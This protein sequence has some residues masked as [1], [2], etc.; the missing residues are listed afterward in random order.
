MARGVIHLLLPR[1]CIGFIDGPTGE[2][3]FDW[4]AV[5]GMER[6]ELTAGLAVE[7]DAVP[8]PSG[9]RAVRVSPAAE[10]EADLRLQSLV[11]RLRLLQLSKSRRTR[12]HKSAETADTHAETSH[13]RRAS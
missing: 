2:V 1:K 6:G 10:S 4:S 9:P 8:G 12:Y 5:Q 7:Y 3:A 13:K 11:E